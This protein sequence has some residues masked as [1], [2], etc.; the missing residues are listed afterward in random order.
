MCIPRNSHNTVFDLSVINKTRHHWSQQLNQV[1]RAKGEKWIKTD[2]SP[3]SSL[4]SLLSLMNN[5]NWLMNNKI[6]RLP[7]SSASK[8][9]PMMMP[10]ISLTFALN[11]L[12]ISSIFCFVSFAIVIISPA[13][14]QHLQQH[15]LTMACSEK[16]R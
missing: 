2:K 9:F 16:W 4:W 11:R 3:S 8:W 12:N 1:K 15:L 14:R 7:S 13:S 5:L 6:V 10:L